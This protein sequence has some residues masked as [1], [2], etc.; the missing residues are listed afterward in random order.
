MNKLTSLNFCP[1]TVTPEMN[2]RNGRIYFWSTAC[3]YLASTVLYVG[4]VQAA[5]CDRLSAS[6]VVA[7]LPAAVSGMANILPV[8]VFPMIHYRF[9]RSMVVI[10]NWALTIGLICVSAS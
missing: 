8:I 5:L 1:T 4:V 2:R 6:P 9:E 7:N 3:Y 10:G